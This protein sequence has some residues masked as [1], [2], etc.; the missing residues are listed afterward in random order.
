[1][2]L[3]A[4]VGVRLGFTGD[5]VLPV[6]GSEGQADKV[7]NRLGHFFFVEFDDNVALIGLQSC[8]E[9]AIAFNVDCWKIHFFFAPWEVRLALGKHSSN[10][11]IGK[12][13]AAFE[14]TCDGGVIHD[15]L[16]C[17][18]LHR[19]ILEACFQLCIELHM[20]TIV[21]TVDPVK[22]VGHCPQVGGQVELKILRLAADD[23][24]TAVQLDFGDPSP[25]DAAHLRT[26]I[27][28]NSCIADP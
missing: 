24:V 21:V 9:L 3:H 8:V 15:G 10:A 28:T 22:R 16:L 23:N 19:D 5:G 1:M 18:I 6:D 4:L 14:H 11:M 20:G 2:E 26:A 25:G 13:S 12:G 17:P 27:D 7:G